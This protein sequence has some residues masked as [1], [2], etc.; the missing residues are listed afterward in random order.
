MIL[1]ADSGASKTDWRTIDNSQ[2]GQAKTIGLNPFQLSYAE[3]INA[4]RN[5]LLPQISSKSKDI[6]NIFFYGAGCVQ[7]DK[8]TKM[9]SA[10]NEVFPGAG[11]EVETDLAA[12]CYAGGGREA[13]IVCILGTGANSCVFDGDRI[14]SS[15]PS[16]GFI[17]AD[18]GSGAFLGKKL[19]VSYYRKQMP[20][21]LR[22][23]F[24]NRYDLNSEIVLES[25]Y[26]KPS[27]AGYLASFTKFLL[28]HREDP[29]VFD[30]IKDSFEQ[31]FDAYVLCYSEHQELPV[32]F[33]GSLAFYYNSILRKVAKEKNVYIKNIL[34]SPIAGL[35]L[36]HQKRLDQ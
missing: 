9:V 15:Q 12:A 21:H 19:I 17:L 5:E 3:I 20:A 34:E 29:F 10:L 27:A 23:Q 22:K 16:L 2:I 35:T 18:E 31:F 11:V 1:I 8:R 13:S 7:E 4:L 28:H 14:V 30:L 26:R 25:I 6:K 36:Y 32:H 24:E 33:V